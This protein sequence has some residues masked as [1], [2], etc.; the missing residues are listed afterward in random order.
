M[1]TDSISV[2]AAGTPA[3]WDSS[4]STRSLD[5]DPF[6]RMLLTADGTVTTLL[7]ASTSEPIVTSTTRQAGPTTLDRVL[8]ATGRWW[9][10]D[11]RLL[12][13]APAERLIARRVTLRGAHSGVVYVLAESLVVP[14]RLP[15]TIADRLV[16][17]GASLR[18]PARSPPPGDPARGAQHRRGASGSSRRPSRRRTQ[19]HAG[20]PHLHD[21]DRPTNGRGRDRM[22]RS[23]ALGGDDT[24]K[25][26][27]RW[28]HPNVRRRPL[29]V[30]TTAI[31]S[32]L[33]GC[34]SGRCCRRSFF[35]GRP[36]PGSRRNSG[37]TYSRGGAGGLWSTR[38]SAASD[39]HP[40]VDQLHDFE[41][42]V[43]VGDAHLDPIADVERAWPA[44]R[45]VP[46]TRT[47]PPR[48]AAV[49][50]ERVLNKR[51]PTATDRSWSRRSVHSVVTG[52]AVSA[53]RRQRVSACMLTF[54]TLVR[55]LLAA[56]FIVGG[57]NAL[58]QA[59]AD[60]GLAPPLT[61]PHRWA[62]AV[63]LGTR[64]PRRWSR[65]TP[66]RKS[67]PVPPW[68][69]G[70]S[71][72]S[73]ASLLTVPRWCRR[74]SPRTDSG[75]SVRAGRSAA[76]Q[77][78]QFAKNAGLVGG[79]LAA[80]LDTG[81]RPSVFW[82]GRRAAEPRRAQRR[83]NRQRRVPHA[84]RRFL[85]GTT[86]VTLGRRLGTTPGEQGDGLARLYDEFGGKV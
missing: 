47:W 20:P 38:Q 6:D 79:L 64:A 57:L 2:A 56:P 42:T 73:A 63:G 28:R 54:R 4:T 19:C 22:A 3:G 40:P 66:G 12:E 58:R 43:A 67:A 8:A 32:V 71:L 62:S 70:C 26:Q 5:I 69:W 15:G 16:R 24:G 39:G 59:E 17:A 25:R 41:H 13:L 51:P 46:L 33:S 81:G 34:G 18:A 86:P 30:W 50:S 78:L 27:S 21:R 85:V 11:A 77:M 29:T 48:H 7:E 37:A 1:T 61:S 80:A 60:G 35:V 45:R 76:R 9:H 31:R 14:D 49:A 10:P 23:R 36:L 55:P 83:R 65:P 53:H 52:S 72:G 75:T 74:R 44:W 68:R 84:P 82:C